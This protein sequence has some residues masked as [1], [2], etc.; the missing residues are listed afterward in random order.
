MGN[1]ETPSTFCQRH[2][3]AE[4]DVTIHKDDLN[5]L[6]LA[7]FELGRTLLGYDRFVTEAVYKDHIRIL[8]QH[9]ALFMKYT[10]IESDDPRLDVGHVNEVAIVHEGGALS[11]LLGATYRYTGGIRQARI[12]NLKYLARHIKKKRGL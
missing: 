8:L 2:L 10:D 4:V 5:A 12:Q 1:F 7:H 11:G 6:Y 9:I 3:P